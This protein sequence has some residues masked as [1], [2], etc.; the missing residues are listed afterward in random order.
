MIRLTR[1]SPPPAKSHA[2]PEL[3]IRYGAAALTT[4]SHTRLSQD[5]GALQCR[6]RT[7]G[8]AGRPSTLGWN[9]R[10]TKG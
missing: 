1:L 4:A 8:I 6:P 9:S 7:C 5:C 10:P 3:G 2:P